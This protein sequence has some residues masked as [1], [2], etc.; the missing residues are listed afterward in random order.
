MSFTG[1]RDTDV[2]V[3]EYLE[4]GHSMLIADTCAMMASTTSI[5]MSTCHSLDSKEMS[6]EEFHLIRKHD[7]GQ[8]LTT[9]M[10]KHSGDFY[11]FTEM[12]DIQ[13]GNNI[14]YLFNE[15]LS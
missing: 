9:D 13:N 10:A 7:I 14:E 2:P 3:V 5:N 12:N 8:I 4:A 11:A 15:D 6:R 1:G